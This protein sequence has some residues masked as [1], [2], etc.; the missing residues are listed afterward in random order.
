MRQNHFSLD[1]AGI[2]TRLL[3]LVLPHTVDFEAGDW[4]E[5]CDGDFSVGW[6]K[7]GGD[8]LDEDEGCGSTLTCPL[9]CTCTG[10]VVHCSRRKLKS[11]PR[12]IPPTTTEL[13][14]YLRMSQQRDLPESMAWR[15]IG[16]LESGQTQRSV[17]DAVGVARSVVARLWN[18]FQE[19]GN[20]RRRPGAARPRATTS[21]DDRYIQALCIGLW[22]HSVERHRAARRRWAAEHP[23]WEQHDWSQVLFTD[24][25]RFSLECDTRRVLVWRDKGTRNNPTFVHERSQ[26]RRAGWMVWGGIS[27][28]GRTDLHIIRNGTLTGRRNADEILR[29]HVIPYA[30]AIGDSFVFQ[31]DNARP[32]RARLVENMLEA[33]TIQRMEWPACSPDLSNRACFAHCLLFETWRLHFLRSGTCKNRIVMA[34]RKHL[35]DFLR[36]RISGRLQCGLTQLEVFEELG[37]AQ[38]VI[39]RL[40]QR[41]QDDGNVSRCYSAGR[42]RVTTPNEDRYLA[43]TAKRNRRSTASDLSRL[44]SSATGTTVSR[45][46]VYRRSGNISLYAR[47]PSRFSLQSDSRRTLIW[48]APGTRYHQENTIERHRYG[49]AGWLVWGGIILGSRTDLHIQSVTMTGHIYRD[50]ILEQHVRLFRGA[51]GAEFLFMDDNARPHRANIVDECLQS[52]DI[53]RMDWPAFSPDLNPIEHVWDMLG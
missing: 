5:I 20:V 39:S 33:E 31:D 23:D 21:T 51:M 45:Q 4:C 10:T 50:V 46:T 11:S 25:S 34:Q 44:L 14:G 48:R 30:G 7:E 32:H 13:Q 6:I 52:E 27:I 36:G 49:G 53:T 41:F 35:D 29:P 2:T 22:L 40:W 24:E 47:R 43:V 9:G 12:N 37:I 16:R 3:V 1:V 19:T 17:A 28:G 26:Y 38:S 18:R 8:R 42:P 15:V